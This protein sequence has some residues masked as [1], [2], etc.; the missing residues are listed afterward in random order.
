MPDLLIHSMSEFSDI[1]LSVLDASDVRNIVEIGAEYGGNSTMLADF[2]GERNGSLISI[3]PAPKPEFLEWAAAHPHVSHV[4]QPSLKAFAQLSDVDAWVID[5]DHNWYTVYNELTQI[6]AIC[7][8]DGKPLLAL[9][10]D[11]NWP[12]GRRDMYYAPDTIPAAFRHRYA[13]D[14][15]AV[16]GRSE[17][18]YGQ[19]FRGMGHFAWAA[20]EGGPRNGVLTAIEDFLQEQHSSGRELGFAEIPA[21]FGL[22]VL[23]DLDAEWSGGVATAVLPYHDNKL[24]R[25]LEQ[26]RLQNYL[27]VIEMQDA[28]LQ[29]NIAA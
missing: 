10:H 6:D 20:H 2:V 18:I 16:P 27:R 28:T 23:F 13:Y 25:T 3:D 11:V 26:N 29:S 4:A 5:G 1:I 24:I 12:S 7:K 22:G 21:V 8:R 9:L 14:G 15:G 19:G 17:L